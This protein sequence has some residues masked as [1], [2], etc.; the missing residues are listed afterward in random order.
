MKEFANCGCATRETTVS[1]GSACMEKTA[2]GNVHQPSGDLTAAGS[3]A[4]A[5][6]GPAFGGRR[7]RQTGTLLSPVLEEKYRTLLS[8][9]CGLCGSTYNMIRY[10]L[11]A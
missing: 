1:P 6:S 10:V 2:R 4:G 5:E 7:G 8:E 3:F 11:V 9:P